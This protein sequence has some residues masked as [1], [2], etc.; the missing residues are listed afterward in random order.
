[1]AFS[2]FG[3]KPAPA[4]LGG[5]GS[6]RPATR[7]AAVPAAAKQRDEL[8]TLDFTQ[9]GEIPKRSPARIEVQETFHQ[10]PAAIEQAAVLFSAEQPDAACA[11]LEGAIRADDLGAHARRA[12]GMLFELYQL[13]GRQAE[14][15]QLAIEFAARFE[16][17]PPAWT[18]AGEDA[19][20]TKVS[21][22]GTPT[23]AL[24]TLRGDKVQ[25][26]V[27]QLFRH[28]EKGTAVRLS[29][30]KV[31][32]FDEDGCA[33]LNEA[34]R[35]LKRTGKECTLVGADKAVALLAP[36][37]A[38]GDRNNE[39]AWLLLLELYQQLGDQASF[40]EAAVNY[41]ITFE[42]SPPSWES[43]RAMSPV[44]EEGEPAGATSTPEE[45]AAACRLE[46]DIVSG[47]D[48]AFAA[49]DERA[50]A[51]PALTVDVS[52]VRRMDFVAAANLMNLVTRLSA[53]G[54]PVRFVGASHLLAA[55]WEIIGL[56]RVAGIELRK[57]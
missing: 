29:L 44:V 48:D 25:E 2:L 43:G 13:L 52:R 10:I 54:K 46:G 17:S 11:P 14:F 21:P 6:A 37:A 26:A 16:T 5:K 9:P 18:T 4:P 45:D 23:A 8:T 57:A 56:D 19:G 12:W 40:D 28:A 3:K 27:G 22:G 36:V 24:A 30:T 1:M 38:T 32:D 49:I 34:L 41:A 42:V 31:A 20:A 39:Q 15:E 47:M 7:P 35:Q 55:L 51:E 50:G 53:T 33:L